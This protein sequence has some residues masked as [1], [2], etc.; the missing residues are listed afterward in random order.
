MS[1]HDDMEKGCK[2]TFQRWNKSMTYFGPNDAI[3]QSFNKDFYE[4]LVRESIQN[5]LDAVLEK[6]KPVKVTY[7]FDKVTI[8]DFPELFKLKEHI[9]GC[10]DTHSDTNR[11]KELYEPMLKYLPTAI[12][13]SLDLIT[14]LFSAMTI[15]PLS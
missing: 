5:S 14:V 13:S 2:W 6:G 4:S 1:Y 11:A 3:I 7:S 10:L 15:S 9:Q 8:D 12:H